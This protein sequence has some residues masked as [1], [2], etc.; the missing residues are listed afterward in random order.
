DDHQ[1][2]RSLKCSIGS[3]TVNQSIAIKRLNVGHGFRIVD[4]QSRS[5]L[6]H[7]VKE[8]KRRRFADVVSARFERQSPDRQR[9]TLQGVA[10]M[11]AHLADQYLFLCL[12]DAID[13]LDHVAGYVE[14]I[15]HANKCSYV[16]G[17]TATPVSSTG[18]EELKSNA[19]VV[20]DASAHVV[21]V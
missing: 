2:M 16:F 6:Q 21:D 18:E 1:A 8:Y 9:F 11:F 14:S 12:V 4:A 10:V 13:G 20:A 15:R 19:A 3:I 17:K 7:G 5:R